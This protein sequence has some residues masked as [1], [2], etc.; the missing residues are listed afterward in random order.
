M[1]LLDSLRIGLL[2]LLAFLA[3]CASDGPAPPQPVSLFVS[4]SADVNNSRMVYMLIRDVNPK[5]FLDES[6]YEVAAKAFPKTDDPTLLGSHP[7]YPGEK[8]EITFLT[9]AKGIAAIYFLFTEPGP[10]WKS[11][12]ELPIQ[13]SYGIELSAGNKVVIG[14]EPGFFSR[15][16]YD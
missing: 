2:L 5:Q 15:M 4:A 6:Y 9:P 7:I 11:Q 16:S 14:D 12:L 10:Y 3:G 1:N 13:T 8:R